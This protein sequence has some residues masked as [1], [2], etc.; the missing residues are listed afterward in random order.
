MKQIV[1]LARSIK[2]RTRLELIKRRTP[3]DIGRK[4]RKLAAINKIDQAWQLIDDALI[5]YPRN[6]DLIRALRTIPNRYD[7]TFY[8][9]QEAGSL[10]SAREMLRILAALY[11]FRSVVDLGAGV[12]TWLKAAREHGAEDLVGVEGDWVRGNGSRFTDASY[13]YVDLNVPLSLDRRFDLAMSL[14]VAE[15][16]S[17][18]RSHGLVADIC[19]VSDVVMFGAAMPRQSG[20]AHINGRPHS[21]WIGLFEEQG[22]ACLD[23]FRPKVWY[24]SSVEPWYAQNTFLFV[25][26]TAGDRFASVPPASL[27]NVYHPLMVNGL[28][29]E[30]ARAGVLDPTSHSGGVALK[31]TMPRS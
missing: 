6:S 8:E 14:E 30:D 2:D 28:V 7:V 22:F 12:G 23:L 27:V 26:D 21:F 25:A 18:D 13:L 9:Y 3:V 4:A 20:S 5:I 29:R 17:P 15:H 1:K 10:R 24:N 31:T 16:L 11:R 19:R